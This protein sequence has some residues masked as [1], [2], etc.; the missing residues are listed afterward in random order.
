MNDK[1]KYGIIIAIIGIFSGGGLITYSVTTTNIVDIDQNIFNELNL[2]IDVEE[3]RGLCDSGDIP[4]KYQSACSV[5]ELI[6]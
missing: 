2:D 5:L 4:E 1:Q 3:L 6:P